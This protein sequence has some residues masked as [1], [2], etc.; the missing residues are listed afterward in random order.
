ML[1]CAQ[2]DTGGDHSHGYAM[3]EQVMRRSLEVLAAKG[4]DAG[5]EMICLLQI[6]LLVAL[7]HQLVHHYHVTVWQGFGWLQA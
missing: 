5:G 1:R 6:F 4:D 2:H 7:N 3:G